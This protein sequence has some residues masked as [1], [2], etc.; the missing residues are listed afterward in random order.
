MDLT[1][2]IN[3]LG[4]GGSQA[5]FGT[6]DYSAANTYTWSQMTYYGVG[7]AGGGASLSSIM[8][9]L[10]IFMQG[11]EG[12]SSPITVSALQNGGAISRDFVPA[13]ANGVYT[14]VQYTLDQTTETGGTFDPTA[15]FWF[16]ASYGNFGFG[17]DSPNTVQIDNVTISVVPEPSTAAM[18]VM[19]AL[20]FVWLRRRS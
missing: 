8:I 11:S 6:W 16:R 5:L 7:G 4:V 9:S 17:Y 14:H 1:A 15:A 2:G 12:S 19:G 20:G 10:D 3:A 13:L 18:L